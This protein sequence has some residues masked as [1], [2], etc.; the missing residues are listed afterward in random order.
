ML[1][2]FGYFGKGIDGYVHYMQAVNG[3]HKGGGGDPQKE[4]CYI[5]SAV[6]GSYDCPEVWTLRRFRDYRL[7]R[8]AVGRAFVR[9]Y[10]ALSPGLVK[11]FGAVGW[12]R[13][14]VRRR[15][16]RFVKRLQAE[17]TADTPY[18]DR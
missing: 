15:L 5:A 2:D 18:T 11:R 7:K 4:G 12:L 16:D 13:R 3:S 9:F 10:Y 17:G 8:T 6:Y 14:F 1:D